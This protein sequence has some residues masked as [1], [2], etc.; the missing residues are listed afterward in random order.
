MRPKAP[1]FIKY[2][3]SRIY[4]DRSFQRKDCWPDDKIRRYILSVN[5]NRTPYPIVIADIKSGMFHSAEALNDNSLNYYEAISSK[6]YDWISL[7]G[8]QRTRAM[9]KFFNDEIT[10]SGDFVDA[11]GKMVQVTNKYF[12]GL[13]QRLQDKFNDVE[14]E[15]KVMEDLLRD[16]L[17]DFLQIIYNES[18]LKVCEAE[19]FCGSINAET[20]KPELLPNQFQQKM[21]QEIN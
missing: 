18:G 3:C 5:K 10:V 16:E 2:L 13:P 12:S 11:D 20:K 6:G 15:I 4:T 17:K 7:D 14:V 1:K 8:I 9:M 21:L 19:I